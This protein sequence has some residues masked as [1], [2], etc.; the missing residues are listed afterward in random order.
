MARYIL[1]RVGTAVLTVFAVATLTFFL[2][3]AVPGNPFL[4]EKNPPQSVLD[5]LNEKYGLDQPLFVQ[6]VKYMG[7]LLRGDLGVSVKM[8][9]DYPVTKI[10]ADMFPVS[11]SIGF[12]SILWAVLAGVPLG[13]LAAFWRGRGPDS[14]LRVVCTVG[15]SMP[16]FVVASL[17]LFAFCGGIAGWK[18][19]PTIFRAGDWK[20]YILP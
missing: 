7:N 2:M 9:K 18:L 14:A 5:A 4:S 15:V 6:F 12:F 10:I 16:S 20:S 8:Q 19:F 17:L 13:C 3:R 11:A 1:K